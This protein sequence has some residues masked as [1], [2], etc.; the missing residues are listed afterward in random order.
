MDINKSLKKQKNSF[1]SFMLFMFLIFVLLPLFLFVSKKYDTFYIIFLCIIEALIVITVIL[2]MESDILVFKN[3]KYKI[4]IKS[5]IFKKEYLL[6]PE[7]V[8]LIHATSDDNFKIII[9]CSHKFRNKNIRPVGKD[10]MINFSEAAMMYMRLKKSYPEN[11]YFYFVIKSGDNKKYLLLDFLFKNCLNAHYTDSAM[12][13]IK[14][15]RS[16]KVKK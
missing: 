2:K 8:T 4:R 9:V 6:I 7:K 12:E 13:K 3:D 15:F 11:D 10:F 14:G 16:S 1:R 5:G